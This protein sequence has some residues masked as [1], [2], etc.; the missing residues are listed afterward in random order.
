M[1]V[2]LVM[3]DADDVGADYVGGVGVGGCAGVWPGECVGACWAELLAFGW[4]S[5]LASLGLRCAIRV[6]EL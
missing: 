4:V 3:L 1:W 6:R 5:M 2:L